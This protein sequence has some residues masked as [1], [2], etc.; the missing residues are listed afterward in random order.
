M[1]ALSH[2]G[3]SNIYLKYPLQIEE[4]IQELTRRVG[5]L[6]HTWRHKQGGDHYSMKVAD[7]HWGCR[8]NGHQRI[9]EIGITDFEG[10]T[11]KAR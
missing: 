7:V 3:Y 1:A 4:I 9:F 2:V 6:D 8:D 10:D 5:H 11:R